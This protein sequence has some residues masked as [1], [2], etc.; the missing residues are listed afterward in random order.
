MPLDPSIYALFKPKSVDEFSLD[1]QNVENART[2]GQL[3]HLQL[4]LGQQKA[5]EYSRGLKEQDALRQLQ[6]RLVG[7]PREKLGDAYRSAGRWAEGDAADKSL[8]EHRGKEG[9]ISF[10]RSQEQENMTKVRDA[11]LAH[12]GNVVGRLADPAQAEQ[13]IRSS[14]MDPIVGPVIEQ[15]YGSAD[16]AIARMRGIAQSPEGFK[17]W[18]A[19]VGIGL[20]KLAEMQKVQQVNTGDATSTQVF[21]P[22]TGEVRT[23]ATAPITQSPDNAATNARQAAARARDSTAATVSK[24]FEVTGPDGLPMLVQQDKKGNIAPVQGFGPKSGASKPL[25]DTQAK[26]LLFGTRMQ[27]ADKALTSLAID[28]DEFPSFTKRAAQ[29]IP[30][31]G[32]AVGM[33]VNMLPSAIGGPSAGQQQVEQ[34]QRDFI[35][36]V[37]RRESGAVI[38]ESEFDNARKQYFP[39]PGDSDAVKAQ[40]ARNRQLSIDGLLAEV[41]EGRRKSITPGASNGEK[42]P[43]VSNW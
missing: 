12:Y 39:E 6:G 21:Q 5:D 15:A 1:A 9:E 22:A 4:L 8:L 3:N 29:A 27:E 32:G 43:T 16:D 40:K 33:G 31:V 23:V 28:G 17:Q 18:Q 25:N 38:S 10:K 42:K 41:P 14:R 13:F 19:N 37:L 30:L 35:N 26:A 34:A 20:Q 2:G 36:A 11:A 7:T 24:P